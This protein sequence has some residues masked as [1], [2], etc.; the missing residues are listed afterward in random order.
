MQCVEE[1]HGVDILLEL[2]A[3]KKPVLA[4]RPST[5]IVEMLCRVEEGIVDF[6]NTWM[7]VYKLGEFEGTFTGGMGP[8]SD[9]LAV[10]AQN[11]CI[12]WEVG[13]HE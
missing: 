8:T 12:F 9:V 13:V 2:D 1:L 11:Y 6:L 7:L 5:C 10:L 4:I 3:Q